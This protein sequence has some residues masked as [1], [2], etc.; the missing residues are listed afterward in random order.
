MAVRATR[1]PPSSP[2][3]LPYNQYARWWSHATTCPSTFVRDTMRSRSGYVWDDHSHLP[4]QRR[5]GLL[6]YAE[7]LHWYVV[8]HSPQSTSSSHSSVASHNPA[9]GS[10]IT[11][12]PS[13][14]TDVWNTLGASHLGAQVR[15][16]D[17]LSRRAL[18]FDRSPDLDRSIIGLDGHHELSC[19]PCRG[20]HSSVRARGPTKCA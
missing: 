7:A 18:W 20:V 6:L 11:F 1:N 5:R 15:A 9:S 17:P 8:P 16:G 2:A 4:H 10:R 12:L 14:A 3:A 19:G 13:I